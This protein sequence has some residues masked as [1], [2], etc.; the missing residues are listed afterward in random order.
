[1]HLNRKFLV[2]SGLFLVLFSFSVLAACNEGDSRQCGEYD[3]GECNYGTQYCE[4]SKWGF[5][6]G[7]TLPDD[8]V[9]NDSKDNDCD[10]FIDEGCD[11]SYGEN[12]TC[13]PLNETGICSYGFEFCTEYGE[14]AG[15]CENSTL[16]SVEKCGI[17]NG[18]S[19]DDNCNGVVDEGCSVAPNGVP[20]TCTNRLK[21]AGEDGFDCGGPCDACNV[22]TDGILERD[23]QKINVD[24]GNGIVSDCGGLN[25]PS[26]PTC[27]DHV[28]NQGEED[29]DCG[30]PC[31]VSCFDPQNEDVDN[32]GLTLSMELQKGTD[33]TSFDTDF[34]GI[35][36]AVDLYPLCPNNFCDELRGETSE[37][38]PEDCGG[39]SGAGWIVLL[40]IVVVVVAI[41]LFFYFQ[42]KSSAKNVGGREGKAW[43]GFGPTEGGPKG[44]PKKQSYSRSRVY[45]RPTTDRRKGKQHE[46]D[47]EKM[48]RESVEAI[49]K[50]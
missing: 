35:N 30:G 19:L 49:R 43:K 15:D 5:C 18:N 33:P 12:K 13:G 42:F 37:N 40:I 45:A 44:G 27:N 41:G 38:C 28:M 23:E 4:N 50:K 3:K 36:D 10:G 22:C 6:L 21:D 8:E 31:S 34:D 46:S 26:C 39:K 2:S 20:V 17:G 14:W 7:Q 29:V 11:C 1:M 32:D 47:T 16:P 9:C 24:L 48:L 25:C